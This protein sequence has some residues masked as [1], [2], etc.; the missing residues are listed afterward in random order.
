MDC[1]CDDSYNV[2]FSD[3]DSSQGDMFKSNS[4]DYDNCESY[5]SIEFEDDEP[6]ELPR[7]IVKFGVEDAANNTD[8]N[9]VASKYF[10]NQ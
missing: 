1:P 5:N 9:Y 8:I 10:S 3:K 6:L 2:S 7:E 4:K